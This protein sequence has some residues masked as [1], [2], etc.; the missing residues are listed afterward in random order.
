M[1]VRR[2]LVLTI[3]LV[4]VPRTTAVGITGPSEHYTDQWAVRVDGSED[5]A[6]L[7]AERHGFI[8]VDRVGTTNF[9]RS[10]G[11]SNFVVKLTTTGKMFK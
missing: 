9:L 10:V 1:R 4:A 3:L 8:Y 5:D 11:P 6:R 7:L 2:R